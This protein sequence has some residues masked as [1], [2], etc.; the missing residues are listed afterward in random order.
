M[1]VIP[2]QTPPITWTMVPLSTDNVAILL[3]G[4]AFVAFLLLSDIVKN[5][6]K[7]D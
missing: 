3:F 1:P 6:G 4:L 5:S 7:D 2:Q